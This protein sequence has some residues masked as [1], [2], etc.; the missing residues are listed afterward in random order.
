MT[1]MRGD[2]HYLIQQVPT[3]TPC[4]ILAT[5]NVTKLLDRAEDEKASIVQGY[6]YSM[7]RE[8]TE[9]IDTRLRKDRSQ[10]MCRRH[11]YSQSSGFAY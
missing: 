10:I 11:Y 6:H 7:D 1:Q 8:V 4:I 2:G 5:N 3:T 9:N